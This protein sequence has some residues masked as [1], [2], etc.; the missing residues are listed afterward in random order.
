MWG[1]ESDSSMLSNER[2]VIYQ[3]LRKIEGS[4]YMVEISSA[5]NKVFI[6]CMEADSQKFHFVQ[7]FRKQADS[8]IE[9]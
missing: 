2:E 1:V 6:T 5:K 4:H 7:L 8:L 9:T 3:K